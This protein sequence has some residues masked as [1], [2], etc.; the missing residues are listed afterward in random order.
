MDSSLKTN[1]LAM[2]C[3]GL[4]IALA[5]LLIYFFRKSAGGYLPFILA[6]PPIGVAAY[7]FVYNLMSRS[8]LESTIAP[9][10]PVKDI[11]I[12]SGFTAI[13][14]FV[15]SIAIFFAVNFLKRYL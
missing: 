5:G 8:S 14:F 7:V 10:L 15:F 3:S 13:V 4:A 6:L 2:T 9:H 11:L 12:G 1:I